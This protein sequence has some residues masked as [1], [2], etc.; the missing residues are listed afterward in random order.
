MGLLL[1][2]DCS[3]ALEPINI[4]CAPSGQGGPFGMETRLGWGLVGVISKN[5]ISDTDNIGHS[6]RIMAVQ[7]TGSQIV[8]PSLTKEVIRLQIV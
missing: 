2:Y 6:H 7:T 1:G 8:R 4:L 3:A 5:P